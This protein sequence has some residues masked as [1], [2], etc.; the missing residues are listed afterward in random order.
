MIN[1]Q[2]TKF[3]RQNHLLIPIELRYALIRFDLTSRNKSINIQTRHEY[4]LGEIRVNLE[5]YLV[6]AEGTNIGSK[7]TEE[8]KRTCKEHGL[9][10]VNVH[11][12]SFP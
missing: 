3:N 8:L 11:F 12:S 2:K 1:V 4:G 9:K 5:G 7:G 6:N 10:V